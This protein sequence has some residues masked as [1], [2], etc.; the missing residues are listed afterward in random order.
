MS[1]STI[2]V[3][4]KRVIWH[5]QADT[6]A[7]TGAWVGQPEE[8]LTAGAVVVHPGDGTLERISDAIAAE[9]KRL[10]LRA[11]E[12]YEPQEYTYHGEPE[13]EAAWRYA[14]ALSDTVQVWL[15]LEATRR[16]RKALAEEYGSETRA[17]PG[18]DG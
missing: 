7:L 9:A 2:A 6:G 4:D 13:A 14:R 18:L 17:L 1:S 12:R 15:S 11:P 16:G 8:Q 3:V 5:V 10:E